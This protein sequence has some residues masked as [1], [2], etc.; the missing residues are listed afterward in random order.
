MQRSSPAEAAADNEA[1]EAMMKLEAERAR[2]ER[3]FPLLN[4]EALLPVE[5]FPYCDQLAGMRN[6]L[7]T[8]RK[9]GLRRWWKIM[10]APASTLHYLD[11]DYDADAVDSQR[12][13]SPPLITG[14]LVLIKLVDLLYRRM[15]RGASS[16]GSVGSG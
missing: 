15:R 3:E 9:V 1:Y 13:H 16:R 11:D 6:S 2:V 4:T 5:M 14:L 7:P 12:V 8:V 10:R